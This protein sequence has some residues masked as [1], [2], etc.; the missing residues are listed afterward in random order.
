MS[1]GREF[2]IDASIIK[3]NPKKI[4]EKIKHCGLL[5][6]NTFSALVAYRNESILKN[7]ILI[8]REGDLMGR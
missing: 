6:N 4:Y 5:P 2:F 8:K 7:S 1:F 3:D